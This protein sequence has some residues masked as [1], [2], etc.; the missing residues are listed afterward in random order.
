MREVRRQPRPALAQGEE[1]ARRAPWRGPGGGLPLA[2]R[3][4]CARDASDLCTRLVRAGRCSISRCACRRARRPR[5]AACHTAHPHQYATG[6]SCALLPCLR[7]TAAV[8]APCG[9]SLPAAP[10]GYC[11]SGRA[12]AGAT[13]SPL[14]PQALH[15]TARPRVRRP[16][17]TP[18][19]RACAG[20]Q[21]W[22]GL[23]AFLSCVRRR[24][25]VLPRGVG[26]AEGRARLGRRLR[27]L[28]GGRRRAARRRRSQGRGDRA[29]REGRR[30]RPLVRALR[31]QHPAGYR[32]R[33]LE[34]PRVLEARQVRSLRR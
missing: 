18:R 16:T 12:S 15:C 29:V 27:L 3:R 1:A 25:A 6:R 17:P 32:R 7:H 33:V 20:L 13:A 21:W 14:P 28:A 31:V 19:L 34:Y 26:A 8:P 22:V 30:R 9:K 4:R 2:H 10:C 23:R 5:Q 11:R 24:A